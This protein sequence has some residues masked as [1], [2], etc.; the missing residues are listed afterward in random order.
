MAEMGTIDPENVGIDP[1]ILAKINYVGWGLRAVARLI[2]LVFINIFVLLSSMVFGVFLA[3]YDAVFGSDYTMQLQFIEIEL[4][5]SAVYGFLGMTLYTS[6]CEGFH[7]STL[8]KMIFGLVVLRDDYQKCEFLPALGRGLAMIIDGL[9]LGLV[10][11]IVMGSSSRQK[12]LGDKLGKTIVVRRNSIPVTWVHP[13]I[14]F[15]LVFLVASL[16]T[17]IIL[18]LPIIFNI[19]W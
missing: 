2:D 17:A 5:E 6:I 7:G 16:M 9:F 3:M 10:A 18:F 19:A 1:S 4:I 14:H 11:A 15:A 8:G 12:R 13:L